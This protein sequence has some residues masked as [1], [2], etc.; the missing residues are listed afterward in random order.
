M[1][2]DVSVLQAPTQTAVTVEHIAVGK[3]LLLTLSGC[4][5]PILNDPNAMMELARKAAVA[6][7]AT[8]MQIGVQQFSPQG[9][10]AFA[11][12]AESHA[13]LH[14]YP[15]SQ[16]VFWDCF[17]CGNSCNPE[18]S[19]MILVDALDPESINQQTITRG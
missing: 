15:E 4:S 3:H 14:T 19:I 5:A 11:V 9:L 17:T 16:K 18:K 2:T 6:T 7:G 1:R 10:T 13:S 8:I 12:L